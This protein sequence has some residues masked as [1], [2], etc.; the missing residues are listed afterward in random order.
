MVVG[1]SQQEIVN[2]GFVLLCTRQQGALVLFSKELIPPDGLDP[3]SIKDHTIVY[4]SLLYC[5]LDCVYDQ[6]EQ[7]SLHD[8][9]ERQLLLL[10]LD[11]D[12]TSLLK[13]EIGII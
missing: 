7:G 1:G 3:V 10:G 6:S 4:I 9:E 2:L 13:L 8:N 11:N 12:H 5:T